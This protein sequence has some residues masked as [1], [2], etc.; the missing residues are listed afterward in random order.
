[1]EGRSLH[2][3]GEGVQEKKKVPKWY[4]CDAAAAAVDDDDD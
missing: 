3:G 1:M 4:H 2:T